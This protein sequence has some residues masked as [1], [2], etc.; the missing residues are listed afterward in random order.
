MPFLLRLLQTS[1][2][3]VCAATSEKWT[4]IRRLCT[5]WFAVASRLILW[6]L[7]CLFGWARFGGIRRGAL[8]GVFVVGAT[9]VFGDSRSRIVVCAEL[10]VDCVEVGDV[11]IGWGSFRRTGSPGARVISMG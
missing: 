10:R 9:G 5:R 11:W 8:A 7:T 1:H 3:A 4:P 2:F 6:R